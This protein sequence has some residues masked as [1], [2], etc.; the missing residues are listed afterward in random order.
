MVAYQLTENANIFV[1]DEATVCLHP[2]ISN[3]AGSETVGMVIDI[4]I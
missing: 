2:S 1:R 3:C 4:L